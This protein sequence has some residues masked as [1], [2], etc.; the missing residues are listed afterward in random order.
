MA[1]ITDAGSIGPALAR[2]PCLKD[3]RVSS[4]TRLGGL[5]NLNFL[6]DA[7]GSRY[8][9]RVPGPA[10]SEYINRFIVYCVVYCVCL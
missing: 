1:E 4:V 6:V 10:T 2:V 3:A 7:N 8:V 5:T 9:V